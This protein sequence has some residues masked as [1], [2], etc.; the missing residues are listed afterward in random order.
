MA[1][2]GSLARTPFFAFGR[3]HYRE[4]R[5]A[6]YIHREHRRGRHLDE[7]LA[8]P[9]VVRFRPSVVRSVLREPRLLAQLQQDIARAISES[10]P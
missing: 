10:R 2:A 1:T 7:I 4:E 3:R 9:Y 6:A 5:L 8:D